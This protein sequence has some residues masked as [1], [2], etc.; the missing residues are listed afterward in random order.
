MGDAMDVGGAEIQS[1]KKMVLGREL[2]SEEVPG[3]YPFVYFL[4]K[5]LRATSAPPSRCRYSLR[6]RSSRRGVYSDDQASLL[7][8]FNATKADRN[9][10]Y[11]RESCYLGLRSWSQRRHHRRAK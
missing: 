11:L 2:G 4:L 3:M 7:E 9:K 10:L 5:Q 6:Y 1:E 8:Y